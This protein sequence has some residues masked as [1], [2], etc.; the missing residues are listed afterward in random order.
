MKK[1]HIIISLFLLIQA[2]YYEDIPRS[3]TTPIDPNLC[4]G[5]TLS[6]TLTTVQNTTGCGKTDGSITVSASGGKSPYQ[7]SLNGGVKQSSNIFSNLAGG[8]YSVAV[9]DANPCSFVLNGI[10]ITNAGNTLAATASPTANSAC[11]TPNGQ[12]QLAAT[13]GTPPYK[14]SFNGSAYSTTT[15]YTALVA[16]TYT[17]KAIDNNGTGCE[18][19]IGVT[20]ARAP[21]G[22]TYSGTISNIIA[23]KCASAQCHAAGQKKPGGDLTTWALVNANAVDIKTRTGNFSMPKTGSLT[24]DQIKQIACWVDDGA[25][26]N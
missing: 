1:S 2:C 23:T 21:S 13:G 15:L 4:V 25:L 19:S 22:V 18:V 20:V 7:Y 6:V 8:T 5:S 17:A 9:Y 12:V 10:A 16:G 24:A 14:F 3:S 11:L 26:N